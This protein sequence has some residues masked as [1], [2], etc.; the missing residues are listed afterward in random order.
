MALDL[1]FVE[2]RT[3]E[4]AESLRQAAECADERKLRRDD[5]DRITEAGILS[6]LQTLLGFA[7]HVDERFTG[8]KKTPNEVVACIGH[9]G[10]I[11]DGTRGIECAT[12]QSVASA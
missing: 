3:V 8:R 10:E 11:A 12:N 9:V 6:K 1:K 4:A 5:V 7:L 2:L